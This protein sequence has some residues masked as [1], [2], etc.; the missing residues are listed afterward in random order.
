MY[1][2]SNETPGRIFPPV[3]LHSIY[4]PSSLLALTIGCDKYALTIVFS[5]DGCIP[6]PSLAEFLASTDVP[7]FGVQPERVAILRH[8]KSSIL[9]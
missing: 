4:A 8:S 9:E 5:E 1:S 6:N 3:G 2:T 7:K